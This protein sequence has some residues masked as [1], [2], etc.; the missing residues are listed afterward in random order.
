VSAA[1]IGALL[2]LFSRVAIDLVRPA[3]DH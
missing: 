3:P 2:P 1:V